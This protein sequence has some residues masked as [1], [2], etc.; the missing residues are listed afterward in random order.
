MVT[1]PVNFSRSA[2]RRQVTM[3][4]R[5]REMIQEAHAFDAAFDAARKSRRHRASIDGDSVARDRVAVSLPRA[6]TTARARQR[7]ALQRRARIALRAPR[8]AAPYQPT[9]REGVALRFSAPAAGS[10]GRAR[11]SASLVNETRQG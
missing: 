10:S 8:K 6:H 4:E 3:G 7:P 11:R 9:R 5:Q 2:A 1:R